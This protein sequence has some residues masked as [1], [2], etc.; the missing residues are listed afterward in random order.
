MHGK[1]R[2]L[3]CHTLAGNKCEYINIDE[4]SKR[5]IS[6]VKQE[7]SP[8]KQFNKADKI[9]ELFIANSASQQ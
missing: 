2:I 1:K 4:S 6:R 8:K 9:D 3:L 5:S 7:F